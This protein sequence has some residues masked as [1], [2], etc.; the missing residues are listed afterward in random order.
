MPL[1]FS[2]LLFPTPCMFFP[3]IHLYPCLLPPV[4]VPRPFHIPAKL[5]KRRQLVSPGRQDD[6][7]VPRRQETNSQFRRC[8]ELVSC[9]F[10]HFLQ[11]PTQNYLRASFRAFNEPDLGMAAR[12][13]AAALVPALSC[14]CTDVSRG[15]ACPSEVSAWRLCHWI[16]H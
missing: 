15:L 7:G 10:D 9:T 14:P 2:Y 5:S 12:A 16:L 13:C 3:C 6:A 11:I 1:F 8:Q 4:T